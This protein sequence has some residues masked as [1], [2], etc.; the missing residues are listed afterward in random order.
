MVVFNSMI[1]VVLVLKMIYHLQ[2]PNALIRETHP[3]PW[4][5]AIISMGYIVFWVAL[6][7]GYI[8]TG[9]YINMF[10]NQSDNLS[11]AFTSLSADTK[12]PGWDFIAIVFK[13]IISHDFHWWLAFIAI[14][15]GIPIMLTFRKK[16]VDY[17]FSVYLFITSAVVTWMMNGIRQFLVVAILF[18]FY[19]LLVERRRALFVVI[20][21]ICSLIHQ[22]V[23]IMLPAV[24]F[25]DC[26]PFGKMMLLFV[27]CILLSSFF[28]GDLM[29]TA[30][31][32]LEGSLYQS[33]LEQF[34][35][36]DGAHPLRVAFQSVPIVLAFIRRQ[37]IAEL[38]NEFI[39]LCINMSTV[40]AGLYFIAMLTSGIMIGRLPIY[41][42]LYNFLLIPYLINFVYREFRGFLYMTF[43]IAYLMFY[44]FSFSSSYY[45]SD[46]LGNYL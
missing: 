20:V 7:S 30:E 44:Y 43:F 28:I 27:I 24:L 46:I 17:L 10:E 22:T 6:R 41:F 34:A 1:I 9:S 33:N 45:V 2:Q 16:S 18:G 39:N 12:S 5:Y 21:L 8:D 11:D 15:S 31:V 42:E 4:G 32:A 3:I 14:S 26:K 37:Q 13:S 38:N 19:Y 29:D 23:I 25:V 36:D 40:T 35:E